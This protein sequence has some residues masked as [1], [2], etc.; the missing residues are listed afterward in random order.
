MTKILPRDL[1][2]VWLPS[3]A[4]ATCD[5]GLNGSD[6][7]ESVRAVDVPALGNDDGVLGRDDSSVF[8]ESWR[9]SR[10]LLSDMLCCSEACKYIG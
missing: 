5:G 10:W 8:F 3:T 7:G 9:H 1:I 6:D 2:D 4:G